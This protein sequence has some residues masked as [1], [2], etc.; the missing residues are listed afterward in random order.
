MPL[1]NSVAFITGAGRGLGRATALHL[2]A[3]NAKV[4]V[5]DLSEASVGEVTNLIGPDNSLAAVLDVCN[6]NQVKESIEKVI[7]K[8]GKLNFV[9]VRT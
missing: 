1:S 6:E 2:A 3:K 4:V 5:C 7:S 9:V 8:W